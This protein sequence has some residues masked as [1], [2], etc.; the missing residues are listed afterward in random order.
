MPDSVA[1]A[2]KVIG[3]SRFTNRVRLSDESVAASV[4]IV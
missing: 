1:F 4:Q 3:L 2:I